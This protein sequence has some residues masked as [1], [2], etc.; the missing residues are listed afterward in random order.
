VPGGFAVADRAAAS[1]VRRQAEKGGDLLGSE[2]TQ[3]GQIGDQRGPGGAGDRGVE[4]ALG[5]I[6]PDNRL[7]CHAP[8]PQN[9]T[10]LVG[11]PDCM[12]ARAPSTVRVSDRDAGGSEMATVVKT[13]PRP[14]CPPASP[15]FRWGDNNAVH[16]R[17]TVADNARYR[18]DA[19]VKHAHDDF[20]VGSDQDRATLFRPRT[21]LRF[22]GNG[23]VVSISCAAPQGVET[24]ETVDA[25]Q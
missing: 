22:R 13:H 3:L 7:V 23:D 25:W 17:A 19:R 24:S 1:G 2:H 12:L 21:A 14:E 10:P 20:R 16:V 15:I 9:R 8:S 4:P 6:D 18:V 11:T 5:H